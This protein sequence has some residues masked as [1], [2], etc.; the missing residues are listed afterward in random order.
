MQGI[1]SSRSGHR[2]CRCGRSRSAR[3]D[4]FPVGA[5]PAIEIFRAAA[6]TKQS[7]RHIRNIESSDYCFAGPYCDINPRMN[8]AGTGMLTEKFA[9]K[10]GGWR[11]AAP[12]RR[13][14][15][16][17]VSAVLSRVGQYVFW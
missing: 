6:N 13:D 5:A 14:A 11:Q 12:G 9:V 15:G 7:N 8:E 3:R 4:G 17:P 2:A 10:G 16:K 1:R